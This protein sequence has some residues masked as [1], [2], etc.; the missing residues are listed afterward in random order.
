MEPRKRVGSIKEIKKRQ[1]MNSEPAAA[2]SSNEFAPPPPPHKGKPETV[3]QVIGEMF[4]SNKL[5]G[6][7]VA[8]LARGALQSEAKN[9]ERLAAVGGSGS[10][11]KN[12]ARDLLRLFLKG[13]PIPPLFWHPI[14]V[15][16]PI[17]QKQEIVKMPFNI[18]HA[19]LSTMDRH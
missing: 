10:N 2:S 17:Q 3:N 7:D 14:R 8:R 9:V 15:W 11:P 1:R 13:S 4:L 6:P 12:Y 5:G 18:P 16:D 19:V